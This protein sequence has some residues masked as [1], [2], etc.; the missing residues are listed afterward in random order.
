MLPKARGERV[1]GLILVN[2][3]I[4]MNQLTPS[5]MPGRVK[6]GELGTMGRQG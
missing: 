5:A 1:G 2:L 4:Y 6:V 3:A